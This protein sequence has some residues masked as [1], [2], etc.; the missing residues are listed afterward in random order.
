MF[1]GG[2]CQ[3]RELTGPTAQLTCSAVSALSRSLLHLQPAPATDRA[4]VTPPGRGSGRR[5]SLPPCSLQPRTRALA[6]PLSS[7]AESPLLH[8][9]SPSLAVQAQLHHHP[10]QIRRRP[11][12]QIE[13]GALSRAPFFSPAGAQP[14]EDPCEGVGRWTGTQVRG[15]R[16]LAHTPQL[17]APEAGGK[18]GTRERESGGWRHLARGA[19]AEGPEGRMQARADPC[20]ASPGG[21]AP[22]PQSTP[23]CWEKGREGHPSRRA[24]RRRSRPA[25]PRRAPHCGPAAPPRGQRAHCTRR[26]GPRIRAVPGPAEARASSLPG[27]ERRW[28]RE[29]CF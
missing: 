7:V 5:F 24:T 25:R 2:Q 26:A 22:R 16:A 29:G 21:R 15:P 9:G 6:L 18:R 11:V 3:H 23:T 27:R 17:T 1:L 10:G 28:N 19:P 13:R 8:S 20:G 4:Q 14:A 12:P